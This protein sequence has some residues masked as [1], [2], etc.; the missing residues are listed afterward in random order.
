MTVLLTYIDKEKEEKL[1]RNFIIQNDWAWL[2]NIIF[3]ITTMKVSLKSVLCVCD[4][5]K[6]DKFLEMATLK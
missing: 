6:G 3:G 4:P 1:K 5:I 2:L